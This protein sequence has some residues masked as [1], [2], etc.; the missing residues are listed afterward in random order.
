M[1]HTEQTIAWLCV[2]LEVLLLVGLVARVRVR[3]CYS[4]FALALAWLASA[5]VVGLSPER[6]TWEFWVV[7]ES[8]HALLAL[9]LALE[10]VW[11]AFRPVPRAWWWARAMVLVTLAA[12][13]ILVYAA[14]PGP[15]S[16]H[17]LPWILGALAWLYIGLWVTS[18]LL[19]VPQERLHTAVLAG[20]SPYLILYA[21]TWGQTRTD[22][23]MA[24]MVNPVMFML[25]LLALVHAAWARDAL[26]AGHPE[27]VRWL[28]PWRS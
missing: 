13:G 24:N 21:I 17:V 2:L 26:V 18:Q 20:L 15:L 9:L 12:G 25:A 22:T 6:L 28:F 27:T 8:S 19:G 10:L 7:T 14:W 4:L 23:A 5:L 1:S 11:R 3:Q 16:V